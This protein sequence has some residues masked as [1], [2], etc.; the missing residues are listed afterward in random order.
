MK[1]GSWTYD[2][3]KVDLVNASNAADLTFYVQ[4]GEWD[5]VFAEEVRLVKSAI[6]IH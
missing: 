6:S 3:F 1:F 5:L 4:N 2:G